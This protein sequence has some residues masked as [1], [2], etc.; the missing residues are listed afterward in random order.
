MATVDRLDLPGTLRALRRRSDVSQRE[1]A[2]RSGVPAATLGRIESGTSPDPRL[3]TVER[4]VRATGAR[5]AI[6]D[7]DGTE[8]AA[9]DTDQWRDQAA[10]RYPPH[11]DP[12]PVNRWRKGRAEDVVSFIR[13]RWIRDAARRSS[14]GERMGDLFAEIRRLGPGDAGLLAAIRSEAATLSF[15]GRPGPATGRPLTDQEAQRY[16]RDPSVRHWV[17][18]ARVSLPGASGVFGQLVAHLLLDYAGAPRMVITEFGL[19]PEQ[20]GSALGPLLVAAA[21]DEADR[22]GV[23]EILGLAGDPATAGYLCGLG[24][25]RWRGRWW[26]GRWWRGS[27]R[28]RWWGRPILLRPPD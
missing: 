27:R 7:L 11:L 3:R 20:R 9:L 19:R 10:R 5:L 26:R 22:C 4:L 24:F 15:P 25:R 2:V 16:L 28:G 18:E 14:T 23:G 1:L 12:A 21:R 17:A 6:V 8:P 13:H